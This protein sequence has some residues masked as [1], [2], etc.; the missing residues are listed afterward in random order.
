MFLFIQV[1]IISPH[2]NRS[3]LVVSGYIPLLKSGKYHGQ[4]VRS[5][6]CFFLLHPMSQFYYYFESSKYLFYCQS[7]YES[8]QF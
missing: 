8:F 4:I 5:Y 7:C 2:A 1:P 6:I 3:C